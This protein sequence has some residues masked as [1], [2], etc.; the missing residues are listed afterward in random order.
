MNTREF[1]DRGSV[2][3]VTLLAISFDDKVPHK[4]SAR[5]EREKEAASPAAGPCRGSEATAGAQHTTVRSPALD[6]VRLAAQAQGER[7]D[8]KSVV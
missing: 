8:R 7:E 5:R 3:L 4:A 1:M 6:G 2:L